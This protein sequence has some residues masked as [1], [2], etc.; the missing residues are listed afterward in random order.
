MNNSVSAGN[1]HKR[2]SR[3]NI[4]TP[5]M[6]RQM[7]QLKHQLDECNDD[8][9]WHLSWFDR[10][11]EALDVARQSARCLL[12]DDPFEAWKKVANRRQEE[13]APRQDKSAAKIECV[14]GNE[15]SRVNAD[16]LIAQQMRQQ[17]VE[18]KKM[19]DDYAICLCEFFS[20]LTDL[21]SFDTAVE[22]A[23][24]VQFS[25]PSRALEKSAKKQRQKRWPAG[26]DHPR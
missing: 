12:T 14:R 13:F 22:L 25:Q 20:D 23:E 26:V 17:V 21:K 18:V 8:L 2:Q 5:E 19:L 9:C 6:R 15:A 11:R 3:I 16:K 4:L 24:A 1:N 10:I 7:L